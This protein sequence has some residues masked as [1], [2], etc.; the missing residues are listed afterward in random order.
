VLAAIS[1]IVGGSSSTALSIDNL[2]FDAS[3]SQDVNVNESAMS[4]LY[5]LADRYT[6]EIDEEVSVILQSGS[7]INDAYLHD[8]FASDVSTL[9]L[10]NQDL[11]FYSQ[12]VNAPTPLTTAEAQRFI[13]IDVLADG[14]VDGSAPYDAYVW[15]LP[16]VINMGGPAN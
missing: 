1:N 4:T 3:T 9:V 6:L 16:Y 7:G 11:G 2:A 5:P 12:Q 13:V 8:V 15:A 14:V 10:T